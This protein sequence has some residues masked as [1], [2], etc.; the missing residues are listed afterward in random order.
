[1]F[2]V[3]RNILLKWFWQ[4]ISEWKLVRV[5]ACVSLCCYDHDWRSHKIFKV[6]SWELYIYIYDLLC[7]VQPNLLMVPITGRSV[8]PNLGFENL[9]SLH[10]NLMKG[11]L[12][13]VI[14]R[15]RS[16]GAR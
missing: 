13:S 4:K 5:Y 6:Y 3:L 12:I 10:Q 16:T 9:R 1:M 11:N 2:T 15:R 7:P 8:Y 14:P